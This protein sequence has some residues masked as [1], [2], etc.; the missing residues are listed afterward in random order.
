MEISL[1][2]LNYNTYNERLEQAGIKTIYPEDYENKKQFHLVKLEY[3]G[4]I[5]PRPNAGRVYDVVLKEF[6]LRI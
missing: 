2:S 1:S 5:I 3:N 4:K 6:N